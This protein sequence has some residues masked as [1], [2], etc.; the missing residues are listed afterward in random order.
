MGE[1]RLGLEQGDGAERGEA[2]RGRDAGDAA[3][4]D[5]EG[6][7]A[8][9]H[10]RPGGGGKAAPG[11]P[12]RQGTPRW[13]VTRAGPS[14]SPGRPDVDAD[15]RGGRRR[16]GRS[17]RRHRAGSR[18]DRRALARATAPAGSIAGRA[19]RRSRTGPGRGG[20]RVAAGSGGWRRGSA[21]TPSP[22][23][24][25]VPTSPRPT[26]RLTM[27]SIPALPPARRAASAPRATL[28]GGSRRFAG[29]RAARSEPS[30]RRGPPPGDG[31]RAG[32][33][34]RV[35]GIVVGPAVSSG[36]RPRCPRRRSSGRA[37]PR[38]WR[39]APSASQGVPSCLFSGPVKG[40]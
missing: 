20:G 23:A 14:S 33:G 35:E 10:D 36:S 19:R 8:P 12:A 2:G 37:A 13:T 34:S 32:T 1:V 40:W 22:I 31:G 7:H 3:A 4:D 16:P 11:P 38:R 26:T 6:G 39:S 17:R 29:R 18:R 15:G 21:P 24:V 9:D 30:A 27:R 25:A 5:E 28:P